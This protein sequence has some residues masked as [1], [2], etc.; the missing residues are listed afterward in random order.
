MEESRCARQGSTFLVRETAR[1]GVSNVGIAVR[2]PV[3]ISGTYG[4]Y[5][6]ATCHGRTSAAC[7]RKQKNIT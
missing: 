6:G 1:T 4:R 3:R 5:F 7:H 2:G